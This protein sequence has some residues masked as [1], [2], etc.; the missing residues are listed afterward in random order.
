MIKN[1]Y[2]LKIIEAIGDFL[3]RIVELLSKEEFIDAENEMNE[4]MQRLSGLSAD[5]VEV[6]S[7]E[8]LISLMKLD[9]ETGN[10]KCLVIGIILTKKGDKA[11]LMNDTDKSCNYY[12]KALNILINTFDTDV[13][14]RL[15]KYFSFID[16]L[17]DKLEEYEFSLELDEKILKYYEY[18]SRY[19][20]AE[21]LL[22]D[23][24]E[25]NNWDQ[26]LVISGVQFYERLLEKDEDELVNGN[27][28][29]DEV[30]Q[31]IEDLKVK[32]T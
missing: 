21:D 12:F 30:K 15:T 4:T 26:S 6:L 16:Y 25:K 3:K 17:I 13:D 28:P 5:T 18:I 7:Y 10:N 2:I 23:M 20:K 27:L 32:L 19:D 24:L 9:W 31:G 14:E 11:A 8:Q 29:I 1:D 22:F